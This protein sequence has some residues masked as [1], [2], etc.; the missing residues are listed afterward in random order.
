MDITI[1][2]NNNTPTEIVPPDTTPNYLMDLT[3][4]D[5]TKFTY[6]GISVKVKLP[7][8]KNTDQAIFAINTDGFIPG[9]TH[10]TRFVEIMSN[11]FP[12]QVFEHAKD[13]VEIFYEP[14]AL[15]IL[16]KYYSY[17]F[18]KG[19]P[20]IGLRLSSNVSQTGNFQV[21]QA[22][23]VQRTY[24]SRDERYTGLRFTGTLPTS[25]TFSPA[26]ITI[27]DVSI[28]RHLGITPVS[29]ENFPALDLMMKQWKV[30][31]LP[32][33]NLVNQIERNLI[34]SQFLEEW[35]LF[36]P[37]NSFPNTNGGDIDISVY[38]DWS[39]V[40][41]T[42]PGAPIQPVASIYPE[43]RILNVT[44]SIL[45]KRAA[46]FALG[47][48]LAWKTALAWSPGVPTVKEENG[49]QELLE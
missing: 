48:P 28:N 39:E 49:E 8:I 7:F 6:T 25:S 26:G 21:V 9:I 4:A 42:C 22:S 30:C 40:E 41:F 43:C 20:R 47:T 2:Q 34:T 46:D 32:A 5:L 38:M 35:L 44:K 11:L 33:N 45:G 1:P 14:I 31:T 10:A 19:K 24:I 13:F 18:C 36:T 27:W 37:Q 16:H 23:G 3:D 15:P 17:R 29:R 12:V